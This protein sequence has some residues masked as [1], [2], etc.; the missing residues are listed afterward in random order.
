[1]TQEI[2]LC[3][4]ASIIDGFINDVPA[5]ML[6]DTGA[7]MSIVNETFQQTHFPHVVLHPGTV[8]ATSVTGDPVKFK[9]VFSASLRLGKNV[10]FQDFYVASGF[11]HDCVLGTDFLARAGISINMSDRTLKWDS[12]TM[13]LATDPPDTV[14]KISLIERVDIPPRSEL[15]TMLPI[16]PGC[17]TGL[18]EMNDSLYQSS[19]VYAARSLVQPQRGEIPVK[20]VNPGL[21]AVTLEP[22]TNIGEVTSIIYSAH[23]SLVCKDNSSILDSISLQ[24]DYLS[25][26]QQFELANM[27]ELQS[28]DPDLAHI[29]NYL[30]TGILP[31]NSSDDRKVLATSSHKYVS[32]DDYKQ[33][34]IRRTQEARYVAQQS[35]ERAQFNQATNYDKNAKEVEFNVGDRIWLYTPQVKQGLTSKLAHLWNGPFRIIRKTSPVNVEIEETPRRKTIVH[36]NRCKLYK[37]RQ[38]RPMDKMDNVNDT[39]APDLETS[40]N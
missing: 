16:G 20:L 25:D 5:K 9:G 12:E 1:M 40:S 39:I 21:V 29:I 17:S 36:V 4:P 34:V 15:F 14:W 11:Q 32:V 6:V 7:S 13:F 24:N 2:L 33:E 18:F 23:T 22:N 10:A 38:P 3:G 27:P 37:D 35:I 26:K 19:N 31:G 30:Q 8:N 28:K